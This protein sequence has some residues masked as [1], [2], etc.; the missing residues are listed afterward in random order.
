M[1]ESTIARD[2]QFVCAVGEPKHET[3]LH[4]DLCAIGCDLGAW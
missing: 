4:P 1:I 2:R 3:N